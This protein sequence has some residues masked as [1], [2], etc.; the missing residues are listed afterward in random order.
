MAKNKTSKHRRPQAGPPA[1]STA[2]PA[3]ER[4]RATLRDVSPREDLSVAAE[5]EG[6][7]AMLVIALIGTT[8]FIGAYYH[9][10][11]LQQM[12]QLTGGLA[13]PDSM[14]LYGRD[15]V[16]ALA[17]VM[18][19]AARGQ[20][21][22]VHKTAGVIFAVAVALTVAVVGA[23]RLRPVAAKWGALA[24]GVV[25]AVVDIWEGLAI[26]AAIAAG[27]D[28]AGLASALTLIRWILL[29]VITLAVIAM[30]RLGRR[31]RPRGAAAQARAGR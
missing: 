23:W 31:R 26:E 28:G 7:P 16:A 8:L 1:G 13:M 24:L 9:L 15:H 10:L 27:G 6:S 11:V 17:G 21:N 3:P 5:Q 2:A 12:T 14:L 19:E 29:A 25:F 22:W 4:D 30:L 20:L 18:D